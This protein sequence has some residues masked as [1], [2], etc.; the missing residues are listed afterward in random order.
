[1]VGVGPDRYWCYCS[2]CWCCTCHS[3]TNSPI[4]T[5]LS[6]ISITTLHYLYTYHAGLL[7]FIF[8]TPK[9]LL[10]CAY[11]IR[12]NDTSRIKKKSPFPNPPY[13][14]STLILGMLWRWPSRLAL[15]GVGPHNYG[16]WRHHTSTWPGPGPRLTI[17]TCHHANTAYGQFLNTSI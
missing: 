2:C 9:R 6:F 17:E 15:L 7:L 13:E 12:L 16:N 5:R 1:M 4:E 10:F 11:E 14:T 3:A 8:M